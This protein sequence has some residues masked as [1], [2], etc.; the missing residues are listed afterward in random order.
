[1]AEDRSPSRSFVSVYE[2]ARNDLV[3][4]ESLS[5]GNMGV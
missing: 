1:M 2:L 4:E 5:V 3:A